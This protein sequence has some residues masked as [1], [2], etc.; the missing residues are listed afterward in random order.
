MVKAGA[1]GEDRLLTPVRVCRAALLVW[2]VL[3]VGFFGM[4]MA[5]T[6]ASV[7]HLLADVLNVMDEWCPFLKGEIWLEEGEHCSALRL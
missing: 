5:V 6:A 1:G 4:R 2:A 3:R 7:N